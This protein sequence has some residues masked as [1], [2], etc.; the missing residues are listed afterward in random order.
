MR[1]TRFPP[2]WDEERVRKILAHWEQ[3]QEEAIAEDEATFEDHD[4]TVM[5]VPNDLVPV[6]REL[7]AKHQQT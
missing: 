5:K 1:Q 2:S 6:V 3:T 4:Q 7:I